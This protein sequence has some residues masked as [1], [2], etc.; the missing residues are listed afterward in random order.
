MEEKSGVRTLVFHIRRR[1]DTHTDRLIVRVGAITT[2]L[3]LA[4][5]PFTQQLVQY[6]QRQIPQKHG[7]AVVPRADRYSRGRFFTAQPAVV[8]SKFDPPETPVR[9][10]NR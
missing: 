8:S 7:I 1:D 9:Y 6:Q 5:D 4:V 3:A 10:Q 2:V